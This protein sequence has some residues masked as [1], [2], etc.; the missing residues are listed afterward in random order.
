MNPRLRFWALALLAT[1]LLSLV[2]VRALQTR[3][4]RLPP[5]SSPPQQSAPG[6]ASRRTTPRQPRKSPRITIYKT[7][8]PHIAR[9]FEAYRRSGA[10]EI[11]ARLMRDYLRRPLDVERLR[12]AGFTEALIGMALENRRLALERLDREKRKEGKK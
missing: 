8:P 9:R 4:F 10:K 6:E 1:L 3:G 5:A 11:K 2:A 7:V 12:R